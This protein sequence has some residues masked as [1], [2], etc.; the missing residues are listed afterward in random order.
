MTVDNKYEPK[1][2]SLLIHRNQL[3]NHL[4][5]YFIMVNSTIT[6]LLQDSINVRAER[7]GVECV[8][9]WIDKSCKIVAGFR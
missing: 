9:C 1:P 5:L 6:K 7:W 4:Q 2:M 8:G 3:L